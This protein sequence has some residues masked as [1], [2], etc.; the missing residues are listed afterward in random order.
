MVRRQ[1]GQEFFRFAVVRGG[2]RSSLDDLLDL[3]DW[4]PIERHL[5]TISCAAKGEPPGRRWP[6]SRRCCWRSGTTCR[7]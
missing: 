5:E 6:C 1:I 3:I 4:V 2:G 7:T